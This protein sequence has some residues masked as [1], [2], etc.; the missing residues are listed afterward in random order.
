MKTEQIENQ[1]SV[2]VPQYEEY[3]TGNW[4]GI[5]SQWLGGIGLGILALL[6][7]F[8]PELLADRKW[9]ALLA[10]GVLLAM[11]LIPAIRSRRR[12]RENQAISRRNRRRY[13]QYCKS[14]RSEQEI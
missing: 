14:L 10:G 7:M 1:H 4:L 6:W 3:R 2:Q 12:S 5:L 8:C 9:T 13:D 11:F